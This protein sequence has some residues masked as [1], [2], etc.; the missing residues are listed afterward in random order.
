M[1]QLNLKQKRVLYT[2]IGSSVLML[3]SMFSFNYKIHGIGLLQ[4]VVVVLYS[5]YFTVGNRITLADF[6]R[7]LDV[8]TESAWKERK[9]L[10]STLYA[11][12]FPLMGLGLSIVAVV[13]FCMIFLL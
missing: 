11:S 5:V 8:E 3:I 2:L 13:I 6:S 10:K 4:W 9:F 12:I 1:I 7:H